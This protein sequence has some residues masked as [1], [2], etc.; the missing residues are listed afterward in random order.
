MD[1]KINN[2]NASS[3]PR[4]EASSEQ[5]SDPISPLGSSVWLGFP[6]GASFDPSI[7]YGAPPWFTEETIKAMKLQY[8]GNSTEPNQG[9]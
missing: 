9:R 3:E 2:S 7:R 6:S 5:Q 4:R 8:N 1:T